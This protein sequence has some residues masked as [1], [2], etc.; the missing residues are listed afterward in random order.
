MQGF[1]PDFT[2]LYSVDIVEINNLSHTEWHSMLARYPCYRV[3]HE[4]EDEVGVEY[5]FNIRDGLILRIVDLQILRDSRVPVGTLGGYIDCFFN[6]SGNF[7]LIEEAG[8]EHQHAEGT[9]VI[10]YGRDN[11]V[12]EDFCR[13]GV[14]Y[15]FVEVL[16]SKSL[17][18]T[19]LF[20]DIREDMPHV[21]RLLYTNER[22]DVHHTL[23]MDAEVRQAL[24]VLAASDYAGSLRDRFIEAKSMEL[25]CLMMRSLLR[26]ERAV[27]HK[28]LGVRNVELLE[29]ARELLVSDLSTPPSI[30]ELAQQLGMTKSTLPERF[31]QFYGLSLRNYLL[32]ARMERAKV[33]LADHDLNISQ[34]AWQLGYEHACNFVTAFKRQYGL[35][36]NAYRKLGST[37]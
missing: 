26:Q 25:I 19:E 6:L 33:L 28:P 3:L 35:T 20:D 37:G 14:R 18:E 5:T 16:I 31:K 21:L 34:V 32:Q 30:E 10:R 1:T 12:F 27:S 13:A 22:T 2:G 4:N 17:L 8:E 7:R 11:Q 36:P 24:Q 15:A 29:R 9:C 23:P